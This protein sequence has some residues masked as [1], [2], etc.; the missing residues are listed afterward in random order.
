MLKR[1]MEAIEKALVAISKAPANAGHLLH[2]GTP[3]G[4]RASPC[5]SMVSAMS[6]HP[7]KK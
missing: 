7:I 6:S 2:K 5:R 3:R 4:I 1:H